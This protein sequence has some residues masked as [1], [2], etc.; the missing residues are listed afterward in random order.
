MSAEGLQ[1]P[2]CGAPLAGDDRFCETCGARVSRSGEDTRTH[3]EIDL[4][5][6]AGVTDRGLVHERNEDALFISSD[7]GAAVVVICDGVSASTDPHTAAQVAADVAGR[8]LVAALHR[9]RNGAAGT[10]TPLWNPDAATLAAIDAAQRAVVD[11]P[12]ARE[13]PDDPPAC[14]FVSALW[15]GRELTFGW[16]GDSRAYWIGSDDA[17]RITVDDAWD[18]SHMLTR[19]LG[20]DAPVGQPGVTRLEPKG[21][22]RVIVCSDGLWNYAAQTDELAALIA[23]AREDASALSLAQRL[24][25]AALDAGGQDNITVAVLTIASTDEVQTS[26]REGS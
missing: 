20:A 2:S 18:D 25:R 22:G 5:I 11:A 9:Q 7:D 13:H 14:T 10:T 15:D 8:S 19:W 16:V 12:A 17:R 26:R 4:G 6:V 3:A 24:T 21:A 23:P 1:C